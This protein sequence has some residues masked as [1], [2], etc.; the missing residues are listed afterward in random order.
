M[1]YEREIA[2]ALIEIFP[3]IPDDAKLTFAVRCATMQNSEAFWVTYENYREACILY[4]MFLL[5]PIIPASENLSAAAN[6]GPLQSLRNDAL[7]ESFGVTQTTNMANFS[8]SANDFGRMYNTFVQTRASTLPV[9]K[10]GIS[11]ST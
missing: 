4:A 2:D 10:K 7:G 5:T 11:C 8:L 9:F 6:G 3:N 1:A